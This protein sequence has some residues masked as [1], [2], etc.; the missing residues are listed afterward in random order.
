MNKG[1][2]VSSPKWHYNLLVESE[3][4]ENQMI[5]LGNEKNWIGKNRALLDNASRISLVPKKQYENSMPITIV[6]LDNDKH[7]VFFT[8]VA[9]S[10]MSGASNPIRVY[11]IG[12]QMNINGKNVKSLTWIYPGGIVENS[13]E[14]HHIDKFLK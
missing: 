2:V 3:G 10:V 7:W 14:P 12:W 13:E 11:C 6:E 4:Y 9:G 1:F 5:N 8:K